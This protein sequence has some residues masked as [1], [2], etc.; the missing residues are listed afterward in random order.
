MI[1]RFR[2]KHDP[3]LELAKDLNIYA[4]A[5]VRDMDIAEDLVQDTLL[6]IYE[7]TELLENGDIN[8][9]PYA[10][11]MLRN[12]HIDNIRKEKIR[13]KY[14]DELKRLTHDDLIASLDT[15]DQFIVREAFALLKQEHQEILILIDMLGFKYAEAAET[16]DIAIGTVMSRVS[17]ARKEMILQLE[18]SPNSFCSP[19]AGQET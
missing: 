13:W 12:L 4:L 19:Q 10:F 7:K 3:Y 6:K 8:L 1:F 17:R 2:K 15:E 14:S 11:R 5:L 9:K 16:L 18:I